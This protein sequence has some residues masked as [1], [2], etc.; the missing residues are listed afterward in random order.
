MGNLVSEGSGFPYGQVICMKED[1]QEDK[2]GVTSVHRILFYLT[3][4]QPYQILNL[5]KG[6]TVHLG[7]HDIWESV[8]GRE[9]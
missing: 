1:G 6:N 4:V 5:K 9:Y 7:G 2:Q 3:A 8:C